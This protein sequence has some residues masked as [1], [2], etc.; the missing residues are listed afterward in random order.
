[1]GFYL[2]SIDLDV[3]SHS[4]DGWYTGDTYQHQGETYACTSTTLSECKKYTSFGRARSACDKLNRKVCNYTFEV[5][6]VMN[7]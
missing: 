3:F 5:D 1:M 2:K 4:F 7:R 6:E